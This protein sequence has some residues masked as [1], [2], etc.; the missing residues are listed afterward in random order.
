MGH[1]RSGLPFSNPYREAISCNSWQKM[2]ERNGE[3]G[4]SGRK[5][6]KRN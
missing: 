5:A 6:M 4:T 1:S 3:R 2:G